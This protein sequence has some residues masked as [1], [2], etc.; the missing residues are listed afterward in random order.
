[1][2]FVDAGT[3]PRKY[4]AVSVWVCSS[5]RQDAAG[6]KWQAVVPGTSLAERVA[7]VKPVTRSIVDVLLRQPPAVAAGRV[8]R[9]AEP[10]AHAIHT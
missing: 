1:L 5:G 7:A 4:L 10:L 3:I 6:S 9:N 2:V 8:A